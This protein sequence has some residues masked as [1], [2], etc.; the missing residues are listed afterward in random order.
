LLSAC[1]SR[2]YTDKHH[3]SKA[4]GAPGRPSAC[5][6]LRTRSTSSVLQNGCSS[7]SLNRLS[8]VVGHKHSWCR[9][10][11]ASY[12]ER[13]SAHLQTVGS[14]K[15]SVKPCG[16]HVKSVARWT[17]HACRICRDHR[18]ENWRRGEDPASIALRP[19]HQQ[20]WRKLPARTSAGSWCRR[21]V[22]CLAAPSALDPCTPMLR[23][24]VWC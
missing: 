2:M 4:G 10:M 14:K 16:A 13:C 23:C 22:E 6:S 8:H 1:S 3:S 15:A 17:A 12:L 11:A 20:A 18:Y 19:L 5:H 21:M 9:R 7:A 24:V